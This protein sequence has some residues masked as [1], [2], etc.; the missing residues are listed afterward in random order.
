MCSAGPSFRSCSPMAST[1]GPTGT[2]PLSVTQPLGQPQ[3]YSI[4]AQLTGGGS[5]TCQLKI[6]GVTIASD[7][8]SGSG[9]IASCQIN[10]DLNG[11]WDPASASG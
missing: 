6:D 2:A 5:V 3:F 10:Q 11:S 1:T 4:N 8:V 7:S 9:D